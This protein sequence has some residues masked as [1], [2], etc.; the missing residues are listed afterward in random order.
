MSSM[1]CLLM[2]HVEN[3]NEPLFNDT[4]K[5]EDGSEVQVSKCPNDHGKN[6]ITFVLWTGYGLLKLINLFKLN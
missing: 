6:K 5:L 2:L 4:I 3:G 1:V